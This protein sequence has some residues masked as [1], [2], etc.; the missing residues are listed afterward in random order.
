[1]RVMV[2]YKIVGGL[3]GSYML[4][5]LYLCFDCRLA[6]RLLN[7]AIVVNFGQLVDMSSGA[8]LTVLQLSLQWKYFLSIFF[9]GS[10][11]SCLLLINFSMIEVL[12]AKQFAT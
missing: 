8:V 3:H 12:Y 2:V 4:C 1:M 11:S 6:R 9:L 7:A 10:F 5:S